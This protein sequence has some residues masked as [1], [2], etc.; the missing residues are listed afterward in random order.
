MGPPAAN[1]PT[2]TANVSVIVVT[3]TTSRRHIEASQRVSIRSITTVAAVFNNRTTSDRLAMFAPLP[4]RS[5]DRHRQPLTL[6]I[7]VTGDGCYP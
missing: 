1:T 6:M 2:G 7:F 3:A 4:L 5:R